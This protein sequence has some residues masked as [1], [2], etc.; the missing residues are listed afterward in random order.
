M[1]LPS[2]LCSAFLSLSQNIHRVSF[3]NQCLM[4][5]NVQ[6]LLTIIPHCTPCF[7]VCLPAASSPWPFHLPRST[8]VTKGIGTAWGVY[9]KCF[10]LHPSLTEGIILLACDFWKCRHSSYSSVSSPESSIR[11]KESELKMYTLV[12]QS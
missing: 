1:F 10:H 4:M 9:V 2:S 11:Q 3:K 8:H 7:I 12:F 6:R 5:F